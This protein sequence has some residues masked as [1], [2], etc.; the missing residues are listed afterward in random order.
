MTVV[1]TPGP[2]GG[3]VNAGWIVTDT[4]TTN[5]QVSVGYVP[6]TGDGSDANF[7]NVDVLDD[8]L[9]KGSGNFVWSLNEAPTGKYRMAV[10]ADDGQ[11]PPTAAFSALIIDV[12][13]QRP[14]AVPSGLAGTSQAGELLVKWNQNTERDLAGYEIGFG[15]VNDGNPDTPGHFVYTRDM[16]PKEVITGTSNIVDAKLWGLDDNVEIYYSMRSY[17][18]SGNF[19]DWAPNQTGKPWPLSPDGWLPAPNSTDVELFTRV[20]VGFNTAIITAGL[21]SKLTLLDESNA[22]VPGS[23]EFITNLAQDK[24]VG[25]SF[26]PDSPLSGEKKYTVVIAGGAQGITAQDNRQMT[27]DYR[28]TFTTGRMELYLPAVVR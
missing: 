10:I 26:I 14:P 22:P 7:L 5:V 27:A 20:E 16:G 24:V 25:L 17:D 11:N 1:C 18:V 19:S 9:S 12:T 6:V 23:F 28:W 3:Q 8:T 4:D 13:D 15:V 2:N 21:E